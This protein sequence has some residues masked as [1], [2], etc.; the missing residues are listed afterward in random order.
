MTQQHPGPR[1]PHDGFYLTTHFLI[2]AMNG[3][4]IAD[5]LILPEGALLNTHQCIVPKAGTC[6]T[7]DRSAMM[8]RPA[9]DPDHPVDRSFFKSHP[10]F[11]CHEP[12]QAKPV[13]LCSPM[14]VFFCSPNS[15][16][17]LFT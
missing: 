9:I 4:S 17:I 2:I 5:R 8:M 11:V 10:L 13:F 14:G 16:M 6:S 1:I 7:R 12:T 3:A 15:T